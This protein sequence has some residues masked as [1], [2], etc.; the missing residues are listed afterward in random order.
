MK[1]RSA[2]DAVHN[3]ISG[4]ASPQAGLVLSAQQQHAMLRHR[5]QENA[6]TIAAALRESCQLPADAWPDD[7]LIAHTRAGID[8]ALERGLTGGLDVVGFLS[9]RHSVSDRFDEFPAV[10][11]FFERTDL[12]PDNRMFQLFTALPLAIWSLIRRRLP[13]PWYSSGAADP[14][15]GMDEVDPDTITPTTG[16]ADSGAQGGV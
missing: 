8:R 3:P 13:N 12:A 7:R 15:A 11:H 9:L 2:P 1:D 5:L 4:Q 10:R 6:P 16:P 14:Y